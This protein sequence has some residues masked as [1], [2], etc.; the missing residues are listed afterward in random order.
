MLLEGSGRLRCR[1][2]DL[3]LSCL[4]LRVGRDKSGKVDCGI[5]ENA[6]TWKELSEVAACV[7]I[8]LQTLREA[9]TRFP[10]RR[11]RASSERL[12]ECSRF[13]V[14]AAVN[15]AFSSSDIR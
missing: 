10:S 5:T 13:F 2:L 15:S 4:G 8:N 9:L 3:G 11:V 14:A 6:S 1:I 7:C 12:R